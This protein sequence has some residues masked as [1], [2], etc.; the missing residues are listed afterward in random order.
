MFVKPVV[1][2][3]LVMRKMPI[4]LFNMKVTYEYTSGCFRRLKYYFRLWGP[5]ANP[6][7]PLEAG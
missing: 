4:F 5:P 3:N 7:R 6:I 1:I 2:A